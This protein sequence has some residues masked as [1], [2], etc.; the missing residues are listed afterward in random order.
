MDLGNLSILGEVIGEKHSFD[1]HTSDDRNDCRAYGRDR[2]ERDTHA[3]R[4]MTKASLVELAED[5]CADYLY[6]FSG[7][8]WHWQ[9]LCGTSGRLRKLHSKSVG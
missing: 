9:S 6:V 8:E 4:S 7:N 3:L 5:Y 1:T 2:G